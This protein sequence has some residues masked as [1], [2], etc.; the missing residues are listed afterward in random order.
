MKMIAKFFSKELVLFIA[1]KKHARQI[2]FQMISL[3]ITYCI[4]Y[5]IF[6][7]SPIF[8]ISPILCWTRELK[9]QFI[10]LTF[11]FLQQLHTIGFLEWEKLKLKLTKSKITILNYFKSMKK[12][13]KIC[14]MEFLIFHCKERRGVNF[15]VLF[16]LFTCYLKSFTFQ[17]MS[18]I[19]INWTFK[20]TKKLHLSLI[21][22]LVVTCCVR[23]YRF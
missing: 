18:D 5:F 12:V 23:L 8:N 22:L 6:E 21:F 19:S 13:S 16:V 9:I 4:K 14:S 1:F 2:A 11:E 7:S 10:T 20:I 17:R 3:N 15:L